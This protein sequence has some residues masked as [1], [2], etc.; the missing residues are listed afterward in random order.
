MRTP[1]LEAGAVTGFDPAV[2]T[3]RMSRRHQHRSRMSALLDGYTAAL[4]VGVAAL[5]GYGLLTALNQQLGAVAVSRPVTDPAVAVLPPAVF[6]PVLGLLLVAAVANWALRLGPVGPDAATLAW[7]MSA[8]VPR[9]RLLERMGLSRV[10]AAAALGAALSAP[11]L[12]VVTLGPG[13][14]LGVLSVGLLAAI[15]TE[16]A[17]VAQTAD[18]GQVLRRTATVLAV[19]GGIAVLVLWVCG[20]LV[21]SSLPLIG[22]VLAL[23]PTG[24]FV[25]A[26]EGAGWPLLVLAVVVVLL[27]SA[28]RPRLAELTTDQ[29]ARGGGAM[30]TLRLWAMT[31]GADDLVR[32]APTDAVSTR[33]GRPLIRRVG[34]PSGALLVAD[35]LGTARRRGWSGYAWLPALAW[36]PPLTVGGN[37]VLP[38]AGGIVIVALAGMSRAARGLRASASVPELDDL[39]PLSA[40]RTRQLHALV[41]GVVLAA[42]MAVLSGGLVLL[43][44]AD[45]GLVLLGA[46]AGLGLGACAVRSAYRPPVDF[47]APPVPTPFGYL[48]ASA[49]ATMGQGPDLALVVLVPLVVALLAGGTAPLLLLAQAVVTLVVGVAATTPSPVNP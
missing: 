43:G 38:V 17:V 10:G 49:L 29:L 23:V 32:T 42:M 20:S 24:W 39:L 11:V 18:R 33:R 37:G 47:S 22:H 3:R 30:T 7:W 2:F 13:L 35:L 15:A 6:L 25:L 26:A 27:W 40:A 34:T 45:A 9:S 41:P 19:L 21:P 48:P 28:I 4:S 12:A 31:G 46:V 8:P 14:L 5:F 44:A 16:E 1:Q 36:L